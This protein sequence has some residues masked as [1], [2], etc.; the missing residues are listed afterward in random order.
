MHMSKP[1]VPTLAAL[2][3]ILGS[4]LA[5][6]AT[7]GTTGATSSGSSTL[8]IGKLS[9]VQVSAIDDI[10]MG[11]W[12]FLATD[13]IGTDQICVFSSN[14]TYQITFD[15]T[16][17][18]FLLEGDA[19]TDT[20]PYTVLFTGLGVPA[21]AT[22]GTPI[23][24]QLGNPLDPSCLGVLNAGYTVTVAAADFNEAEADNYSAVLEILVEPE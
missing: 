2:S 4:G 18:N 10:D 23:T 13:M 24:G 11:D 3:L 9:N 5:Q 20:I 16:G 8:S 15:Q 14:T 12:A 21:M 19:T 17:G 6:A 1:L 7:Q 22:P